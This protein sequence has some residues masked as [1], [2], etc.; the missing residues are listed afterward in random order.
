LS[1]AALLV[2]AFAVLGTMLYCVQHTFIYRP[3]KPRPDWS[4]LQQQ[5]LVRL[6]FRTSAGR[7]TA[8]YLGDGSTPKAVWIFF[9]GN[10]TLSPDWRARLGAYGLGG[11]VGYLLVDYPAYGE[12]EGR[13]SPMAILESNEAA[14]EAL[15]KHLGMPAEDLRPRLGAIGHSLGAAT[16]LQFAARNPVRG[17]IL[18]APF[19][20]TDD[21]ARRM[22][23]G[24]FTWLLVHK[25]DNKARLASLGER[26]NP[27][28][29]L[30]V[31]GTND[32][33]IP[34]EMGR[35]LAARFPHFV[36]YLEHPGGDHGSIVDDSRD[37]V[38]EFIRQHSQEP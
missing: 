23:G 36:S 16:A 7:Q 10:S 11:D 37:A 8:W 6:D 22:F 34:V 1:L 24:A 12:N 27:P 19:T 30:L 25:F 14:V 9:P 15:A 17:I 28:E 13:P 2:L 21:M 32:T 33:I 5:G 31:H 38:V 29:V 26:R 4:S 20:S 35:E 3:Q 18:F